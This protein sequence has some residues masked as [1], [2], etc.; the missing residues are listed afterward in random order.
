MSEIPAVFTGG[1]VRDGISLDGGPFREDSVVW[2]LQGPVM[3]ADLRISQ[4]GG[5]PSTCFAGVTTWDGTSLTW[6]RMVDLEHYAG[7]DSGVATWDGDVLV[8]SGVFVDPDGTTT[9]YQERWVRLPD[10][11]SPLCTEEHEGVYAVRTGNYAITLSDER[12]AGGPFRG[13]AWIWSGGRW[14]AGWPRRC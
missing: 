11:A 13:T 5:G 6:T 2:W 10:S 12:D 7:V 1:W 8:E 4:D 9:R 3:H 14:T